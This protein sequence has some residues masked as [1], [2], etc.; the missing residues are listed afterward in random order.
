MRLYVF[1]FLITLLLLVLVF[2]TV[3]HGGVL[4]S[5]FVGLILMTLAIP[6]LPFTTVK[7]FVKIW[8]ISASVDLQACGPDCSASV[9][10]CCI[11]IGCNILKNLF[12]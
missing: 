7:F 8:T 5:W 6:S 12:V 4:F 11:A 9:V 2:C 10:H 1:I 3:I